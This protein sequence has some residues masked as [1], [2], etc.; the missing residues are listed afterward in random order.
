MV[1]FHKALSTSF[2]N[3]LPLRGS[4]IGYQVL[5]AAL[6]FIVGFFMNSAATALARAAAGAGLAAIDF[7]LT[8]IARAGN[9][10]AA[11]WT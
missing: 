11:Y 5:I 8:L 10:T 1:H 3:L 4:F 6:F 9:V 2:S 7:A